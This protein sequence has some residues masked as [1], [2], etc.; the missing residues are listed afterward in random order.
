MSTRTP[1]PDAGDLPDDV[2]EADALD[3]QRPVGTDDE[4]GV[5][6][7][8][9]PVGQVQDADPAD[10]WEQSQMIPDGEDERDQG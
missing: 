6:L 9:E 8:D 10:V 3:Q 7:P 5:D 2:P 4:V 1:D